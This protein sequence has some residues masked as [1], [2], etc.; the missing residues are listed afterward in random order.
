VRDHK[1]TVSTS[2]WGPD[3]FRPCKVRGDDT[4]GALTAFVTTAAP[5]EGP[6]LHTHAAED[7]LLFVLKGTFRFQI[8]D[9]RHEGPAGSFVYIPRALAHTWQN[10][11]DRPATM[12]IVVSP[13]GMERFFERFSEHAG[14]AS[15]AESFRRIGS[16][17]GMDV[18]G[19]PLS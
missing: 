8:A 12:F 11:G 3:R 6:P 16:E 1:W 2:R 7:E 10:I 15:P 4:N 18:V 14:G 17:V 19:P 9:A 13:S 5:G